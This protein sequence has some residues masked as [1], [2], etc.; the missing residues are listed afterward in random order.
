MKKFNEEEI[1]STINQLFETIGVGEE[2]FFQAVKGLLDLYNT[3]KAKNEKLEND[4]RGILIELYKAN[5]KLDKADKK[6]E[7]IQYIIDEQVKTDIL[8]KMQLEFISKD[9]IRDKIKYKEELALQIYNTTILKDRT[10]KED[11]EVATLEIEVR[12]LKEL[13]KEEDGTQM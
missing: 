13:L 4:K 6:N 3:E 11:K 5:K 9:K 8:S 1:I 12:L 7:N 10:K 2:P